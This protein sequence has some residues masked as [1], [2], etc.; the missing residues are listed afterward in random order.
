[1]S[2]IFLKEIKKQ[3][4]SHEPEDVDKL[5]LDNLFNKLRILSEDHKLSL[6]KYTSLKHLSLNNIGLSCLK[7][8][9]KL[10][11]L[12]ILELRENL[13]TGEDLNLLS[14]LC[15]NILKLKLGC[16]PIKNIDYLDTFNCSDIKIIEL[17][18]TPL[19]YTKQY[20]EI[21]FYKIRALE[22]I[23]SHDRDGYTVSSDLS[24]EEESYESSE[25]ESNNKGSNNKS[26]ENNKKNNKNYSF[27]N[28]IN[29]SL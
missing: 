8:F 5:I 13:L 12:K 29:V 28:S 6:E 19:S 26:K 15:P 25:S 20:K 11:S 23:D 17:Y 2:L 27:D 16:N 21:L 7:N 9:P 3:L 1:M 4:G 14:E 22:I 10:P 24:D 18:D